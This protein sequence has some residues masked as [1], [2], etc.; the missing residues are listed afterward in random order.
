MYVADAICLS[1]ILL[2]V[3]KLFVTVE[4]STL[5]CHK[6]KEKCFLLKPKLKNSPIKTLFA[7]I[8]WLNV[9]QHNE[10]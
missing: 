3:V 1:E 6:L 10:M 7:F 9:T 5:T 8:I 4:I 2:K